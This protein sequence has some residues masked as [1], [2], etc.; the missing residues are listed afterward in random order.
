MKYCRYFRAVAFAL[1]AFGYFCSSAFC[2]VTID[3]TTYDAFQESLN[4]MLKEAQESG[5]YG[6]TDML[7]LS[8]GAQAQLMMAAT[9]ATERGGPN[10]TPNQAQVLAVE[11]L[12]KFH[13][14]DAKTFVEMINNGGISNEERSRQRMGV[15]ES[16]TKAITSLDQ[17]VPLP[18]KE[19]LF[20][21]FI[22]KRNREHIA[23]LL[24]T[25][26]TPARLF[27]FEFGKDRSE[28]RVTLYSGELSSLK[29][30][31]D[32]IFLSTQE[33]TFNVA[34]L[35][36]LARFAAKFAEW[37][38]VAQSNNVDR[39]KKPFPGEDSASGY[40]FE[41]NG[42]TPH[43]VKKEG[44]DGWYIATRD[45]VNISELIPSMYEHAV[46]VKK[47]CT[48]AQLENQKSKKTQFNELFQ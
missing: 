33:K 2:G 27:E 16:L 23:Q 14:V 3:A 24:D 15:E 8:V 42:R 35:S 12:K 7:A 44:Y 48:A 4:A 29:I 26:Q 32:R 25:T 34:K 11:Y 39:F 5:D 9:Y 10:I 45:E 21:N 37:A 46:E 1:L 28:D 36:A 19:G 22:F 43:I 17:K 47:V 31:S 40:N 18:P 20:R 38:N 6:A 13:G 41:W 30:I